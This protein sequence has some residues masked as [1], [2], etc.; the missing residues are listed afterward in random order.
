MLKLT[1]IV[2]FSKY[3]FRSHSF[4]HSNHFIKTQYQ[5]IKSWLNRQ[6]NRL[7]LHG[8]VFGTWLIDVSYLFHFKSITRL[9]LSHFS[10]YRHLLFTI[11]LQ[12]ICLIDSLVNTFCKTINLPVQLVFAAFVGPLQQQMLD[13]LRHYNIFSSSRLLFILIQNRQKSKSKSEII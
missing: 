13:F 2:E 6:M 10:H 9:S 11:I 3:T 1:L 12:D 7:I 5:I 4:S 8:L